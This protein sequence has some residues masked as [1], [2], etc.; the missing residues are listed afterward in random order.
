MLDE[1]YVARIISGASNIKAGDNPAFA[2]SDFLAIYP[3]F[4]NS[5]TPLPSGY[6][7]SLNIPD[8]VFDVLLAESNA[9]VQYSRWHSQWIFGMCNYIA[10]KATMYLA[11]TTTATSIPGLIASAA[12]KSLMS[13]KTVDSVSVSYDAESIAKDL[14]GFGDF[15]ATTYG[16]Q[17]A[18]AAKLIG[19]GG[20]GIW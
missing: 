19:K 4:K 9:R 16:Q 7:E 14:D 12:P 1:N 6:T 18:S 11:A 15:K 5:E 13:S 3:Q 10:H 8:A 2:A 20:M 17:F